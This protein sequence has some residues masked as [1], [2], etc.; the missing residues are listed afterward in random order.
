M[1]M[2]VEKE[3]TATLKFVEVKL[4]EFLNSMDISRFGFGYEKNG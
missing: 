3:M 1:E 4:V 2:E